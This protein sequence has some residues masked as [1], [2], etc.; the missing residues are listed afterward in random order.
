MKPAFLFF[1]LLSS[2]LLAC[3]KEKMTGLTL[4]RYRNIVDSTKLVCNG[5]TSQYYLSAKI[6]GQP[7]CYSHGGDG[8]TLN[9]NQWSQ[10]TTGGTS[11]NLGEPSNDLKVGF[12]LQAFHDIESYIDNFFIRSPKW[13]GAHEM[14]DILDRYLTVGGHS[15]ADS[16]RPDSVGFNI[17]FYVCYDYRKNQ[18]G[19]G[20]F[21]S[22]NISSQNGA[23]DRN[24]YLEFT[25]VEKDTTSGYI[26]YDLK[27]RFQCQLYHAPSSPEEGSFYGNLTDGQLV[28][29]IVVDK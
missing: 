7:V 13:G 5:I 20:L 28:M 26:V 15:V 14:K 4:E 3:H 12:Q 1:A 9:L 10:F 24:S 17:G 21:H 6:N 2:F 18:Q 16:S 23:Q 27:A 19:L 11:A 29:Q 25:K 8:Y 22:Q